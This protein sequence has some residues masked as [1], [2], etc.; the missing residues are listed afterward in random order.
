M[1]L[2]IGRNQKCHCGSA[3]KYK[4]CCWEHDQNLRSLNSIMGA[5]RPRRLHEYSMQELHPTLQDLLHLP[6]TSHC[7]HGLPPIP[8]RPHEIYDVQKR[9]V[10][11]IQYAHYDRGM[12]P[13][14]GLCCM[15]E[16]RVLRHA[17]IACAVSPNRDELRSLFVSMGVMGL[18]R[19]NED[20]G[21]DL[22]IFQH[23]LSF[24]I[25]LAEG[26]FLPGAVTRGNVIAGR[27]FSDLSSNGMRGVIGFF[28]KRIPCAC[29]ASKRR[30]TRKDQQSKRGV[31]YGC[32]Q[33][34]PFRSLLKCQRCD[35]AHY[36]GA[37]CQLWNWPVHK[38][39]CVPKLATAT[40][41]T[42]N[43]CRTSAGGKIVLEPCGGTV[44]GHG[45]GDLLT[46]TDT[47]PSEGGGGEMLPTK[48]SPRHE[49]SL[50][51]VEASA[52]RSGISAIMRQLANNENCCT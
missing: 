11:H 20:R 31:C 14:K 49:P 47:G 29:L 3:R 12:S 6:T 5:P 15:I 10:D 46:T 48:T 41:P 40:L 4:Q 2:K 52:I 32:H 21:Y 38:I 23:Y 19:M 43:C 18:L 9:V 42:S 8:P 37:K 28:H 39:T 17:L 24:W 44:G 50:K 26:S 36:C 33:S 51:L 35:T 45:H 16:N 30:T 25:L 34:F 13:N 27:K 7:N 1:S 22:A